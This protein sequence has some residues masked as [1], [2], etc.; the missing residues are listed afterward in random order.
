M[1]RWKPKSKL[2][3]FVKPLRTITVDLI[4]PYRLG[5]VIRCDQRNRMTL[6]PESRSTKHVTVLCCNEKRGSGNRIRVC[7]LVF[8]HDEFRG[9]RRW[10]RRL[11][12]R[13]HYNG[14]RRRRA[15]FVGCGI[16]RRPYVERRSWVAP[17]KAVCAISESPIRSP[18][19]VA[20][21]AATKAIC[22]PGAI[23]S[24]WPTGAS[25]S[26]WTCSTDVTTTSTTLGDGNDRKE[27]NDDGGTECPRHRPP[28]F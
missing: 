28:R 12:L 16:I 8:V 26:N 13:H 5:C 24:Y 20:V 9:R 15:G 14:I 17:P 25:P 22:R 7:P 4:Q 10:L 27:T 6:R 23:P 3:F 18:I 19:R 2:V 11:C 1:Y 21:G